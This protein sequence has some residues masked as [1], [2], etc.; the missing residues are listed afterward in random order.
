MPRP[1]QC[2]DQESRSSESKARTEESDEGYVHNM[3]FIYIYIYMCVCW[4]N[5]GD[6]RNDV[7]DMCLGD[8]CWIHDLDGSSKGD[9]DD[10]NESGYK[11]SCAEGNEGY[12]KEA[13]SLVQ[14]CA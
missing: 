5:C 13:T 10:C 14:D 8:S 11:E 2:G 3:K 9:Y 1:G 4:T 12:D 7:L 6:H